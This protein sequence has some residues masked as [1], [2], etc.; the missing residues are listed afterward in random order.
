VRAE[1]IGHMSGPVAA[2]AWLLHKRGLTRASFVLF[3]KKH[4]I[5]VPP[6]ENGWL[7]P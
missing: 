3:E 7:K 5:A 1:D 2:P 4:V 6:G